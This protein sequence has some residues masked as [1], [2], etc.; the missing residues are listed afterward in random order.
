[1]TEEYHRSMVFS[2]HRFIMRLRPFQLFSYKHFII[3]LPA[4]LFLSLVFW[5]ITNGIIIVAPLL[6]FRSTTIIFE[7]ISSMPLLS[8]AFKINI[9]SAILRGISFSTSG[10]ILSPCFQCNTLSSTRGESRTL[11]G[12]VD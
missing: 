12:C 4:I 6:S 9:G 1:M 2:I 7:D 10:E 11:R 5:F 3:M 8:I